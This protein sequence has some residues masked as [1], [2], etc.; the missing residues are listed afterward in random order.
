MHRIDFLRTLFAGAASLALVACGG[1]DDDD[2]STEPS[3]AACFA[4]TPGHAHSMSSGERYSAVS[5]TF[6]GAQ[7]TAQVEALSSGARSFANYWTVESNG[8]RFWG[9]N[10]Y[11]ENAANTITTRTVY[12]AGN[13]LPTNLRP[14]QSVTLTYTVTTTELN[15]PNPDV[16]STETLVSAWSFEAFDSLAL[17][18]R[19]F[20]NLCRMRLTLADGGSS[21]IWFAPGF[22]VI[23]YILRNAAGA[24]KAEDTLTSVISP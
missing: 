18:G 14:G 22:G 23:R 19:T 8:V 6:D 9:A 2:G 10:D 17:G 21:Q 7:R 15:P 3:F 24:T 4:L 16:V 1:G 12:S 5:E 11:A 13:T 20:S